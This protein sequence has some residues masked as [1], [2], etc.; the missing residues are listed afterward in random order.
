MR[1]ETRVFRWREIA[2]IANAQF[3]GKLEVILEW[4]YAQ[5]KRALQQFPTI[6][7]PGAEKILM[8]CGKAEGLPLESNGCRV[9]ERVGFG[10]AQKS[11]G[12]TY[13]SIQEALAGR[14]PADAASLTEA[15]VLLRQHGKTVCRTS[16]PSCEACCLNQECGF[17][18][19]CNRVG[20]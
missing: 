10:R 12:A 11:Y 17:G 20:K 1:P 9:L 14:L 6:G 7:Q 15:H 2:R 13:R 4:P 5:A 16:Q 3:G 19:A 18:N 8:L